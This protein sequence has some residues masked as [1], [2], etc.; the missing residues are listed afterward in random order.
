MN[1]I[2]DAV[3][4]LGARHGLILDPVNGGACMIRLTVLTRP[5][6]WRPVLKVHG[7]K[8]PFRYASRF[9][10]LNAVADWARAC[11]SEIFENA[12]KV[13]GII[14]AN[15]LSASIKQLLAKHCTPG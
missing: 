5:P 3:S 12:R 7:Q 6:H 8:R 11:G 13:D 10:S 4:V 9:N 15:N 2:A 14:A 1:L